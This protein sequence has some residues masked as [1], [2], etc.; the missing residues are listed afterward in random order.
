[1]IP[2][3]LE[4]CGYERQEEGMIPTAFEKRGYER[5][6]E[7]EIPSLLRKYGDMQYNNS[8]QIK[9]QG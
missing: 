9:N 8:L 2:T 6:E 5:Q 7:T 3:V 4:K 1:M